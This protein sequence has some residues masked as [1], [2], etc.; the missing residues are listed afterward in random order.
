MPCSKRNNPE[1]G[2]TDHQNQLLN[3]VK[4]FDSEKLSS[5]GLV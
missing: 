2:W 1:P 5:H 3:Q 4:W